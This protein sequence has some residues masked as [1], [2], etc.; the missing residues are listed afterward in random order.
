MDKCY[1]FLPH[2]S[3]EN[4]QILFLGKVPISKAPHK[5]LLARWKQD[6]FLSYKNLDRAQ[7]QDLEHLKCLGCLRECRMLPLSLPIS[8]ETSLFIQPHFD[9]CVFSCGG[10]IAYERFFCLNA[11]ILLTIFSRYSGEHFSSAYDISLSDDRYSSIRLTEEELFLSDTQTRGI[12]AGFPEAPLRG[13]RYPIS[14]G[15]LFRKDQKLLDSIKS[16]L[17]FF[18]KKYHPSKVYLPFGFGWHYDHL[19]THQLL[20]TCLN[21]STLKDSMYLIYEDYPYSHLNKSDYWRRFEEVNK[22]FKLTSQ[23]INISNFIDLKINWMNCYRTQLINT[24][25]YQL[26]KQ[27]KKVAKSIVR[28]ANYWHQLSLQADFSERIWV[29]EP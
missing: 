2:Y 1:T 8:S 25:Y 13:I 4:D 18:I 10:L 6:G 19:I 5:Q 9:D 26:K 12:S 15:E 16:T 29:V 21:D 23:Y 17:F 7:Y 20:K 27:V 28:E 14:S 24:P 11:I 22:S 3:I